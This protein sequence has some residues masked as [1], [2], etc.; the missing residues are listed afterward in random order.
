MIVLFRQTILGKK[1]LTEGEKDTDPETYSSPLLVSP[2]TSPSSSSNRQGHARSAQAP[3]LIYKTTQ[4][5]TLRKPPGPPSPMLHSQRTP[6]PELSLD[7]NALAGMTHAPDCGPVLPHLSQSPVFMVRILLQSSS[8]STANCSLFQN[9][10]MRQGASDLPGQNVPISKNNPLPLFPIPQTDPMVSP[11]KLVPSAPTYSSHGQNRGTTAG[12][13]YEFVYG[14]ADPNPASSA[15]TSNTTP[16]HPAS[17]SSLL[18]PSTQT[19][20]SYPR[21]AFGSGEMPY[22]SLVHRPSQDSPDNQ[23]N[24][25]S[26]VISVYNRTTSGSHDHPWRYSSNRRV[27]SP[28]P[29]RP[30]P[31]HR[32]SPGTSEQ[33]GLLSV[34]RARRPHPYRDDD[35]ANRPEGQTLHIGP[36]LLTG[37]NYPP[38]YSFLD[39]LILGVD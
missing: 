29:S 10:K 37:I 26:P 17:L 15:R 3:P 9:N 22:P 34:R 38:R 35:R 32:I 13:Q 25:G 18:N 27:V 6:L 12:P 20:S 7:R 31:L 14:M 4:I 28:D 2:P 1:T 21:G 23:P 19:I 24:T 5:P 8:I 30:G 16:S 39:S 11:N 36:Q 33:P